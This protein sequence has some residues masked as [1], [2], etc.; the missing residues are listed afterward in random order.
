MTTFEGSISRGRN[1][2]ITSRLAQIIARK[3]NRVRQRFVGAVGSRSGGL[4]QSARN[5]HA[6]E[7]QNRGVVYRVRCVVIS[8]R[9]TKS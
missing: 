8:E 3:D 1:T 7:I 5:Q 2:T 4:T 9:V 6:E